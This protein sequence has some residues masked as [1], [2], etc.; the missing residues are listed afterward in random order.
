MNY[1]GSLVEAASPRK[2]RCRKRNEGDTVFLVPF[3]VE[4]PDGNSS[5]GGGIMIRWCVNRDHRTGWAAASVA[6]AHRRN[7]M[8]SV[9]QSTH[10]HHV[11]RI[12]FAT[13]SVVGGD[14]GVRDFAGN[15]VQPVT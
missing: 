11:R 9:R 6:G 5:K 3:G 2:S 10:L 12:V 14:S 4:L 1:V 13:G 7:A 8:I 15:L